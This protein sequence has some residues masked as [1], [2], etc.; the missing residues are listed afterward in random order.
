[1]MCAMCMVCCVHGMLCTWYAV[2]VVCCV[3]GMLFA[4]YNVCMVC[5]V[6]GMLCV[7]YDVCMVCCVYCVRYAV[8]MVCYNLPFMFF[9]IKWPQY[10]NARFPVRLYIWFLRVVLVNKLISYSLQYYI[11]EIRPNIWIRVKINN[12]LYSQ[13]FKIKFKNLLTV[14]VV[15]RNKVRLQFDIFPV[16]MT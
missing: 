3:H 14:F 10:A 4:W 5:C 6:H 9:W 8:C 7:W 2:Y 1:M 15:T 16:S 11:L 12:I 13:W